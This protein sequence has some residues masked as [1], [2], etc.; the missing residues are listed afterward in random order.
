MTEQG[1]GRVADDAPE[2]RAPTSLVAELQKRHVVRVAIAYAVAAWGV[3]EILDGVI[4]RFGWPDWIATLVVIVF[5]VGFPVAMFLAWV[6]DWTK[7]GIRRTEPGTAVGGMSIVLAIIF[8]VGATAGLFW[9]INPS[10]IVRVEQTGIAVLPCRYRGEPAMAFRGEGFAE[11]I[12]EHL[13]RSP[14]FFVPEFASV[15][16]LSAAHL[17][18]AELAALLDVSWLVECRV[19]EEGAR[20]RIDAT[21]IDAVTDESESLV[22]PDEDQSAALRALESIGQAVFHRFDLTPSAEPPGLLSDRYPAILRALDAYMRGEQSY[23]VG[24]PDA[25]REARQHFQAAQ[26]VPGFTLA[27]TREADTM[28]A[29]AELELPVSPAAVAAVLR[30]IDLILGELGTDADVP[31]EFYVSRLRFTNLADRFKFGERASAEQRREFFDRALTLKP[32]DAEPYRLYAEYLS[33]IGKADN[34]AEFASR[35]EQFEGTG[36]G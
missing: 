32:N 26:I 36:D 10:G 13:A 11:I 4:S 3:T 27:R 24:T 1:P 8:L 22:S 19:V 31:A 15:A 20:V 16:K 34:A 28:M 18:T 7:D 33:S 12:N 29:V 5:V 9:L 21:L 2:S 23:R 17:P 30:A 14:H 25:L 35:A 6:F